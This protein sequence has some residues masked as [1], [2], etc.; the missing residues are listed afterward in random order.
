LLHSIGPSPNKTRLG[1]L[2]PQCRPVFAD[3]NFLPGQPP[4]RCA[5][6]Q[7]PS[8]EHPV[9]AAVQFAMAFREAFTYSGQHQ[10]DDR[11]V[12]WSWSSAERTRHCA[13]RQLGN[14]H[15]PHIFHLYIT[16]SLDHATTLCLT[17]PDHMDLLSVCS[18][19]HCQPILY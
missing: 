1:R 4:S 9:G 5:A 11:R 12:L 10:H 6:R 14:Q 19:C 16:I 18:P 17:G 3:R 8:K 2:T 13:R 15:P 7:V